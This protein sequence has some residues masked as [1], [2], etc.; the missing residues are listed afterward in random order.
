MNERDSRI[1]RV[2]I[3]VQAPFRKIVFLLAI[4]RDF[5]PQAFSLCFIHFPLIS[6]LTLFCVRLYVNRSD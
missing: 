2:Q 1:F 5:F 4:K 3:P 6:I